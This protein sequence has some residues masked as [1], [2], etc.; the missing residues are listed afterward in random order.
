MT[1]N[2]WIGVALCV[3]VYLATFVLAGNSGMM[4]NGLGLAT[5]ISGT[6]GAMFLS[7]PSPQ[8]VAALRVARNTY[9][10]S[11]LTPE[12]IV[13]ILQQLAI[14]T[15]SKGVIA[16]E[17]FRER[18]TVMFL[19]RALQ[20]LADGFKDD[21]ISEMLHSEMFHFRHR[22]LAHER[23]FRHAAKLAP[24]FGV[25]GSVIGLIAMLSGI[26]D[27]RVIIATVPISLTATL[28][29]IVLANFFLSPIAESIHARTDRELLMQ[30]L[31][32]DG[33]INIRNESNPLRL[34]MK[35]ESLLT[36]SARA[37]ENA[38]I[39]ELRERIRNLHAEQSM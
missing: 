34:A 11:A 9:T 26:N 30:K 10:G 16:L 18:T 37:N 19:K 12:R 20:L 4:I 25:A 31:I 13:E 23:L 39:E 8:L 1:A 36:P 33:V 22:R 14:R 28:Y 7:Y 27:P 15:R 2:N 29:G 21:E 6:L 5:V 38:S 24:A 3:C 32:T 35:L 17:D